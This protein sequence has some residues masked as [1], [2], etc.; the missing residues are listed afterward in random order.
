MIAGRF[1]PS[2]TVTVTPNRPDVQEHLLEEILRHSGGV[3]VA[4]SGGTDSTFL[5]ASALRALPRDRVLAVTAVSPSLAPREKEEAALLAK[6]LNARHRFILTQELQNPSY[7]ANPTNRCFFC[8]D[9]LFSLLAPLSQ[10]ENLRVADG[11]NVSDRDDFRPGHEAARRWGVLH[12]LEAAGFTKDDIRSAARRMSLPNWDKPASPCLSSRIPYGRPVTAEALLAIGRAEE[13]VRGEGFRVVRVRHLGDR[14]RVEVGAEELTRLRDESR[15]ERIRA[16]LTALGY[17]EVDFEP[18][19][20][21]SGR[22]NEVAR[23]PGA[24]PTAVR[25]D[26]R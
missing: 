5:V 7:A 21:R 24:V 16:R 12:P 20:Y 22:L 14:A 2:Y 15:K 3:L 23:R 11:F 4:F 26:S 19:G 9:E 8:K 17:A 6:M 10:C 1:L 18:E 13:A 25:L